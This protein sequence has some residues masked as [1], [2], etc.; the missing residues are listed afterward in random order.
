MNVR[1]LAHTRTSFTLRDFCGKLLTS[2][3][4]RPEP[5]RHPGFH[6]AVTCNSCSHYALKSD[7]GTYVAC[8]QSA[9][10]VLPCMRRQPGT[11]QS[12]QLTQL[13]NPCK[14][15]NNV[16]PESTT[17]KHTFCEHVEGEQGESKSS[18]LLL[19]LRFRLQLSLAAF[20]SQW[21]PNTNST[22]SSTMCGHRPCLDKVNRIAADTSSSESQL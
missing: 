22:G 16:I 8:S 6:R 20:A 21:T 13:T 14:N 7:R 1:Y 12:T 10:G 19:A 4:T 2:Q 3:R 5:L 17:C 18:R 11:Q 15:R 9:T